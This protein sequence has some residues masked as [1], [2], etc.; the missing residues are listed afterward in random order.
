MSDLNSLSPARQRAISLGRRVDW[1][2][3]L[4]ILFVAVGFIW[5]LRDLPHRATAFPWFITVSILAAGGKY[6]VGKWRNP[7]AWDDLYDPGHEV[8][9][10]EELDTGPGYV[11]PYLRSVLKAFAVFLTLVVSVIL[12]GLDMA[13]PAFVLLALWLGGE[14]KVTAILSAVAFW[15]IVRFVFG[16]LMS[17]NLPDG[18]LALPF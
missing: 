8:E 12:F 4:A 14:G 7:G 9:H 10:G 16:T 2:I 5:M 17:I 18:V 15:A 13:V 3:T 1:I 6:A 11:V